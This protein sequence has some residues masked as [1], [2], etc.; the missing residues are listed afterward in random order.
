MTELQ[1]KEFD[2]LKA[3][4]DVCNQLE[5]RSYLVCGSA[6]GAVK[7]KGFIPWDDDVD[8]ALLREDYEDFLKK[9][10]SLLPKNIF[11]QDYR[12]DPEFPAVFA[13][14]RDSGTTYIEKSASKL[15]INHGIYIDIFP[16]DGY[17]SKKSEQKKLEFKKKIYKRLLASAFYTDNTLKRIMYLPLKIIGANKNTSKIVKK[18]TDMISSYKVENSTVLAN[19][20]NWQGILDYSPKN[21]FGKGRYAEFEG[22]RVVV[23][24]M[25]EEYL[26]QKYG[27]IKKD[28]PKDEQVGHHYYSVMDTEKPYTEYISSKKQTSATEDFAVKKN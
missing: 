23:P 12:S 11:V 19:H 4:Y 27:D 22:L 3:F 18:Y 24:A 28:P 25:A 8:V 26:A 15:N 9:A 7:Y 1:K 14:L 16:L 5:I 10:P 6:L 2:L 17:P 20:G 21:I 13:K